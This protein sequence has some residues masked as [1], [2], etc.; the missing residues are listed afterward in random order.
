MRIAEGKILNVQYYMSTRSR[1]CQ[2]FL[3]LSGGEK[4]ITKVTRLKEVRENETE[5]EGEEED[6]NDRERDRKRERVV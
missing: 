3:E 6:E 2:T 1:G 5:T 4:L